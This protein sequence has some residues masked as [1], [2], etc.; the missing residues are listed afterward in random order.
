MAEKGDRVSSNLFTVFFFSFFLRERESPT[1][2]VNYV[3]VFDSFH[4]RKDFQRV[5]KTTLELYMHQ[6]ADQILVVL[7]LMFVTCVLIIK[8]NVIY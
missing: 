8:H 4:T 7:V 6:S 1:R 2:V 3:C 5:D